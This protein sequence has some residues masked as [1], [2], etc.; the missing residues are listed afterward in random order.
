MGSWLSGD[1]VD[2]ALATSISLPGRYR[3]VSFSVDCKASAAQVGVERL[4]AV[5]N[6]KEFSFDVCAPC[7][8]IR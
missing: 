3:M 2:K 8:H 4:A 6:S 1:N 7:L 5:D